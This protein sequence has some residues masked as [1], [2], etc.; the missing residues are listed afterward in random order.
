M[1]NQFF[2]TLITPLTTKATSVWST[3][4]EAG[5]TSKGDPEYGIEGAMGLP[6][7]TV[8]PGQSEIVKFQLYLGPKLYHRL[9]Q[10]T[11]DEAEIMD[12]GLW[13]LVS[14]ALLNMMNL[15]HGFV[16]N[17]AVAILILTAII[18]LLLWPL[19]TKANKSMRRMSALSPKMQELKEKYKD[20]PT[21]M[22]AEVMKLYK[23][24]GVNPVERL[25]ADDDPDPDFLR[26]LHHA[27]AGGGIAE[28]EL[29]LGA[30]SV[31]AGHG[32]A[33]PGARL[34]AEHSAL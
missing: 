32:R 6:G 19:Q 2:V 13:K 4:Y 28:R 10:L 31:A 30:R 22:N 20:D 27:A 29:P 8:P 9:A 5:K 25:P 33:H 26:P 15:I 3:R 23:D 7:F 11:H 21:K 18:K 12:F 34:A 17:Y 14:Q 16:G 1:S 24:Y